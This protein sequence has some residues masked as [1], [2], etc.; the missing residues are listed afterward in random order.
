MFSSLGNIEARLDAGS[1]ESVRRTSMKMASTGEN[2]I[3]RKLW[4][5]ELNKK[6]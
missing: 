5:S 3:E 1:R 4:R 2:G 6:Y